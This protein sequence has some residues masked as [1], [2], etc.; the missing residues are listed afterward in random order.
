LE[1]SR[2][3][4][5]LQGRNKGPIAPIFSEA[6]RRGGVSEYKRTYRFAFPKSLSAEPPRP[7][8]NE[9]PIKGA[10]VGIIVLGE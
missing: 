3:P 6:T 8:P 2:A 10:A 5:F 1:A 9:M 7:S 4:D